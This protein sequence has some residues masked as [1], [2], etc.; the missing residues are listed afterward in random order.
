M[1]HSVLRPFTVA[2]L[3]LAGTFCV[4]TICLAAGQD[5]EPP[6]APQPMTPGELGVAPQPGAEPS[7]VTPFG[8]E[9]LRVTPPESDQQ[10]PETP[11]TS[12]TSASQSPAVRL[13]SVP[14]MFG[15]SLGSQIKVCDFAS[16]QTIT[17][18]PL[19]G[20]RVKISENDK[21]LPMC[22]AF[23]S[24]NHFHNAINSCGIG[25]PSQSN[26][27]DQYTLGVEAAFWCARAS[28]E[29]RLPLI[30]SP[31]FTGQ[32]LLVGD[33]EMGNLELTVK[34][35]LYMS[36][37]GVVG[38]GLAIDLPTGSDLTGNG[39]ASSF[40]LFNDAVHLAPFI[41]FL[42]MPNDRIFYQ[43]FVQVDVPTN[44]NRVIFGNDYLGH[45]CEQDLLYV[46]LSL[47]YWLYHNPC[48][49]YL[50]GVAPVVEYH[51]TTTLEDADTVSGFD[52]QQNLTFGNLDN[53]VDISNVTAG[54]HI[55][56]GLTTLRVA[57][58]FPLGSGSNRLYDAEVQVSLNRQF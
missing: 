58:V 53:R 49:S 50:T 1:S 47:G 56:L 27:F 44:G 54:L 4:S 17:L 40:T 32:D 30:D 45:L 29:L 3:L 35:L 20:Q 38:A 19:G 51:Y 57:G 10:A 6:A 55:E 33:E 22:R 42:R 9:D 48:A 41:G 14:N 23:C 43:G 8:E 18:P 13:A 24:Y 52:G 11:D 15:D 36:E 7:Q 21:A 16:C 28:V 25:L 37:T 26:S 12:R 39:F 46:D 5:V 31:D 34:R 2:V